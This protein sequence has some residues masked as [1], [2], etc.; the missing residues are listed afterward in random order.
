MER[1]IV[2]M[3]IKQPVVVDDDNPEWTKEEFARARPISDFPQLAAAFPKARGRPTGSTKPDAKKS[4][5]LRL[6]PDV[7]AAFKA[8]GAGWHARINNALRQAMG[9]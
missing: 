2:A 3:P 6:D 1:S 7:L 8:S 9:L 5:T 4:I